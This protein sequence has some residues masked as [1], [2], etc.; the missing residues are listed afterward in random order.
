MVGLRG[1]ESI[2][3][4]PIENLEHLD[5]TLIETAKHSIDMAAYSLTDHAISSALSRRAEA[6]V[7]VRVY[8]DAGQTVDELRRPGN[9]LD[10]LA[11][12]P[13]VQVRIK[14]SRTL[15]HLKAYMVDGSV[16]RTGSANFSPSGLKRQD[17][18]LVILHDG[19]AV[20]RFERDF[21]YL[22]NRPENRILY[23]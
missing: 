22:W 16:L 8:L 5:V 7:V 9:A 12:T 14:D 11:R 1:S 3:F 23:P 15:M 13:N 21:E 17:N 6:G 10:A 2:H 4:S 19:D 18:D 20:S